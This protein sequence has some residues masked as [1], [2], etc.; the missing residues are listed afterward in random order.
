MPPLRLKRPRADSKTQLQDADDVENV[1]QDSD[2]SRDDAPSWRGIQSDSDDDGR[3]QHELHAEEER[4]ADGSGTAPT[5]PSPRPRS[6]NEDAGNAESQHGAVPM[7]HRYGT[8]ASNRDRRP[9]IDVGLH[10]EAE[11]RAKDQQRAE[12]ARTKAQG[13]AKKDARTKQA[14]REEDAVQKLARLEKARDIADQNEAAYVK[15]RTAHGYNTSGAQDAA[16]TDATSSPSGSEYDVAASSPGDDDD[17]EAGAVVSDASQ[18]IA[19][20]MSLRKKPKSTAERRKERQRNLLARIDAARSQMSDE[21][22]Q[23]PEAPRT[24]LHG[25]G[26]TSRTG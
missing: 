25:A 11:R 19:G 20:G 21:E 2:D 6:D 8:R 7:T 1:Q 5:V 23:D 13:L 16:D 12:R 9:G 10:W 18:D 22:V 15:A 26:G 14:A 17:D 3:M 4:D 24:P